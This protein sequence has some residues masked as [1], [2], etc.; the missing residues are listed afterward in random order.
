MREANETGVRMARRGLGFSAE[1]PEFYV[2]DLDARSVLETARALI[3]PAP[4]WPSGRGP[5]KVV[6]L[7]SHQR[8]N[9]R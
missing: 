3:E 1:G 2:W 4:S 8:K 6:R 5:R 9:G 7:R